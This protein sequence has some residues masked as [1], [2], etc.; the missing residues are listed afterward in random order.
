MKNTLLIA[1]LLIRQLLMAMNPFNVEYADAKKRSRAIGRAVGVAVLILMGCGSVIYLEYKLWQ[2]LRGM[3]QPLL[4]PGLAVLVGMMGTLMLGFF[5]GMGELYQG[6]DSGF[7]AVLPVTS[8]QIFAARLISLYCS[9]LALNLLLMA[10][11]FVMYALERGTAWPYALT[12]L[13]VFLLSP[14]LPM[15]IVAALSSLLMR[16][17]G[18]ARHRETVMMG[19]S[20][21]LAIG[22]SFAVTRFNSGA[23]DEESVRQMVA[24]MSAEN[25]VIRTM[26]NVFPP[27]RWGA[28]GFAGSWG[29][30]ALLLAVSL[31]AA[32][33]VWLIFGG[34][35]L[36]LALS[37]SEVSAP[38]STKVKKGRADLREKSS[39]RALHQLEWRMLLRTPT[40]MMNSFFGM[41]IMPV[42]VTVGFVSG[43]TNGAGVEAA[44]IV[45]FLL[46]AVNPIYLCFGCGALASMVAMINP[47]CATAVSRE[48]GNYAFALT[49][50]VRQ[51]T[52]LWAK[53][54]QGEEIN[55][56]GTLLMCVPLVIMGAP[57]WLIVI[58]F[59]AANLLGLASNAGSLAVDAL[60]PQLK[61]TNETQA[62]KKNYHTLIGMALWVVLIALSVLIAILLMDNPT[63]AAVC[64]SAL[65]LLSCAIA[66][67]L[68]HKAG[69]G[70]VELEL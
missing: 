6:K 64:V 70:N 51:T 62:I 5:Q 35:Y 3:H 55:L 47:A 69:K 43:F 10:P 21:L 11:A 24:A 8:R 53:L 40:W 50:P 9:E 37:A 58:T 46:D 54:A 27:A 13:T 45:P 57:W 68:L 26:L 39:F 25:G 29:S 7:L 60:H 19:L 36:A 23:A 30:I 17:S 18:F 63:L 67:A 33:L 65:L 52:R 12:G 16:V 22:Y 61:W 2:G 44:Q 31:G 14:V 32:A 4:L 59:I 49:L 34:D 66:L 28:D 20:M 42:M 48:G 56:V 41:I 38:G 1:R 15:A